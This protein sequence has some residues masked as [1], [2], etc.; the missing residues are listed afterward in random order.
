MSFLLVVVLVFFFLLDLAVKLAL[1]MIQASWWSLYLGDFLSMS[2]PILFL[3][4]CFFFYC[5]FQSIVILVS[6]SI[7]F[8]FFAG[9]RS[10]ACSVNDPGLLVKFIYILY[11]L[12]LKGYSAVYNGTKKKHTVNGPARATNLNCILQ[13]L[14]S[15]LMSKIK[16][17]CGCKNSKYNER[18]GCSAE[19]HKKQW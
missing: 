16:R 5:R 6:C 10:K 1:W 3:Q 4:F 12:F 9:P 18:S 15:P 8:L 7:S 19:G 13:W 11:I 14:P 17:L 2:S